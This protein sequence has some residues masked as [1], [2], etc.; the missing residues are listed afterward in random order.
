MGKELKSYIGEFKEAYS[1]IS[2]DFSFLHP[3]LR[4]EI[5]KELVK[6]RNADRMRETT[7]RNID[8]FEDDCK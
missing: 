8:N 3:E 1:Q 4:I 6:M 7:A 5:L 2:K